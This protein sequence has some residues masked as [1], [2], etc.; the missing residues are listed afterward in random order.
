MEYQPVFHEYPQ[1]DFRQ[2][3][4]KTTELE[5]MCDALIIF[6]DMEANG[7]LLNVFTHT[8]R[9]LSFTLCKIFPIPIKI[10]YEKYVSMLCTWSFSCRSV[11]PSRQAS[12][13]AQQPLCCR[14]L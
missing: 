11:Y 7:S 13:S 12:V 5:E 8:D 6:E 10:G 2:G 1:V 14:S 9:I 3:V 4:P